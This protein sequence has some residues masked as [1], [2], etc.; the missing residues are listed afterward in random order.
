M[1]EV[2]IYMDQIGLFIEY[3]RI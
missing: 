2:S 1:D 3:L